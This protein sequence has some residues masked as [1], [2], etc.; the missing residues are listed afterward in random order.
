MQLP[1]INLQ[2]LRVMTDDTGMLQHSYFCVPNWE[3][4]YC[5]DDN[6]RALI[7]VSM[8]YNL[9]KDDSV[10]LLIKRYLAFLYNAFNVQTGRFRN[11]LS[12]NRQ[13]LEIVGSEDSHGRAVWALGEAIKVNIEPAVR[14]MLQHLFKQ[15]VL[16]AE[17]FE[18]QRARAFAL[19]GINYYL[20]VFPNDEEV[21]EIRD[22]L[23]YRLCGGF[24][25]HATE[26]WLWFEDTLT[27]ANAQ[28]PH[29]LLL[30]GQASSRSE[31]VA[32]GLKSLQWLLEQQTNAKGQLSLVGNNGWME[33]NGRRAKF[34]QQPIEVMA[35]VRA[36]VEAF[37]MT[38]ETQWLQEAQRCFVWFAG[39]NDRNL[40]MYD[41]A[42]GG[43]YD[44][45]E[46]H[47][48]NSNMG[49][50]STL[51]WLISLLTM[52]E[53]Q[54]ECENEGIPANASDSHS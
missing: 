2:H 1:E 7:A 33:R 49:A 50:E 21:Q 13:W 53:L 45:L 39:G 43:C 35:L 5:T 27:Y 4:G 18:Y 42:S 46:P 11:F 34:G 28:L 16:S 22:A 40:P 31:M 23:A 17:Q 8:Y 32:M 3:H 29:A 52:Y 54:Q 30:T 48:V 9:R 15:C 51:S 47:G 10:L 38:R 24:Q 36:C 6:A 25:E 41:A 12:Y 44:G 14:E 37:R 26:K 20:R 19:I